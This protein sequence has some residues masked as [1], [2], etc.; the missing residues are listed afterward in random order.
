MW[1]WI[2]R[3][4][5]R[6][7]HQQGPC[8][9]RWINLLL[10]KRMPQAAAAENPCYVDVRWMKSISYIVF[11]FQS[12]PIANCWFILDFS[13]NSLARV[14]SVWM[15]NIIVPSRAAVL[16]LKAQHFSLGITQPPFPASVTLSDPALLRWSASG[17]LL[18][19]H[20]FMSIPRMIEK[21]F[22]I[23]D[24]VN[25]VH[26]FKTYLYSC[27]CNYVCICHVYAHTLWCQERVLDPQEFE[28]QEV[29][30]WLI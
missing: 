13:V 26:I 30:N 8:N 15:G 21:L 18:P 2:H 9:P 6:N 29:V 14:I 25:P 23:K 22:I 11:I 3:A 28:I 10:Q 16:G 19:T 20:C 27:P 17:I 24:T 4:Q 7:Q 5:V 12:N 1:V